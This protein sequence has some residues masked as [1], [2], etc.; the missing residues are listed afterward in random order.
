MKRKLIRPGVEKDAAI[1]RGV[2]SD[3]DTAPDLSAPVAGIVRRLGRP[4]KAKPKVS[5]DD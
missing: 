4:P 3:P 2:A 1:A 5:A